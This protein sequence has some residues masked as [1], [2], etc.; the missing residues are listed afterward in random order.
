MFAPWKKSYDQ[1]RQCIKKL[2]HYFANKGLSSQRYGFRSSHVWMR[3]WHYTE[4]WALKNCCFWTS[5]LERTLES[6]LEIKPFILKEIS[7]EYSL[8]GLMLKLKCQYFG[9]L[10]QRADSLEKTLMLGKIEGRRR[11][12]WDGWMASLTQQTRVW[13]SS[14]SWWWTGKPGVLQSMG[15]QRIGHAWAIE[16][17]WPGSRVHVWKYRACFL[18]IIWRCVCEMEQG[19]MVLPQLSSACLL[20]VEKL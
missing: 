16:L 1:I 14:G 19:F 11:R 2:W 18:S 7:L 20:S 4:S 6:P 13:A 10:I 3:E 9:P 12:G 17:N 15:L 5:V 8:E